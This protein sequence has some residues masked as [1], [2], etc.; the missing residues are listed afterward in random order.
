[1]SASAQVLYAVTENVLYITIPVTGSLVLTEV[2]MKTKCKEFERDKQTN[3]E[4]LALMRKHE[5]AV[6]R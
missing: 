5:A 6:N 2:L 4:T 3:E 1:M